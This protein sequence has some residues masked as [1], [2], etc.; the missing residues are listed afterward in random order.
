MA[1]QIKEELKH[2]KYSC[3]QMYRTMACP[4]S[5]SLIEKAPPSPDTPASTEGVLTHECL[6]HFNT[7]TEKFP[8]VKKQLLKA[9][10]PERVLRAELAYTRINQIRAQYP[11]AM[12]YAETKVD[13]SFF[14]E[15]GSFGTVDSAIAELFGTLTVIDFKNGVMPVDAVENPQGVCYALGIAAEH[16]FNFTDV[17]IGI[18]QP[19]SRT[20]SRRESF[21]KITMKEL[22]SWI[23]RIQK[24]VAETKKKNP[25]VN[26]GEWCFFCP[27]KNFNCPAHYGK[28]LEENNRL[29]ELLED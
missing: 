17:H 21:W 12:F 29:F 20:I 2:A 3:S 27:A 9:H 11:G 14:I 18:I 28:K 16:D 15:P 25:K 10:P 4:A 5:I 22:R 1:K 24:A 6:E 8:I 23:P 19:N 7:R 26:P 13:T